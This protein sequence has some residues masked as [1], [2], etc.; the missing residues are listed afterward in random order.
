MIESEREPT[1]VLAEASPMLAF[2]ATA[3]LYEEQPG[4]WKLGEPGRARTLEDF[5]RHFECLATLDRDQYA[6]Y[7]RYCEKLF[8][9]HGFPRQWLTDAW[10]I[11]AL[12]IRRRMPAPIAQV[13]IDVL[14]AASGVSAQHPS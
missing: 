14:A 4:L 6:G 11:M 5:G 7:V 12:V 8:D 1:Q 3:A 9:N 10:R 2:E 13:A